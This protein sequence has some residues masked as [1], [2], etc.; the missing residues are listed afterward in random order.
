M[1]DTARENDPALTV[2]ITPALLRRVIAWKGGKATKGI[3]SPAKRK[4]SRE[5]GKKGGR[6]K[7]PQMELKLS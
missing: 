7:R 2:P 6:K 4:A 5:N 1:T 3:T